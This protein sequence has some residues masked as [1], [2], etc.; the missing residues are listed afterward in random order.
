MTAYR[1]A[2]TALEPAALT[3]EDVLGVRL[4]DLVPQLLKRDHLGEAGAAGS[5][6]TLEIGQSL[7]VV[8]ALGGAV[9]HVC[10]RCLGDHRW[11]P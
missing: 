11:S 4:D 9:R 2:L 7:L 10:R 8:L 5:A 3:Y 1:R 6:V